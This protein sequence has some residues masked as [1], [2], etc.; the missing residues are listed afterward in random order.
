MQRRLRTRPW[1]TQRIADA[2][3]R[4]IADGRYS[5]AYEIA[6][7]A[8]IHPTY[9]PRILAGKHLPS[10][11]VVIRLARALDVPVE[12]FLDETPQESSHA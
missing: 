2:V 10:D 11:P 12:T 6:I 7:A 5:R 4:A 3:M 8:H 1:S 9:L